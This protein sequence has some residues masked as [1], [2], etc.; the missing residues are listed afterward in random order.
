MSDGESLRGLGFF[1][2][3]FFFFTGWVWILSIP[4]PNN[5]GNIHTLPGSS[6]VEFNRVL[7]ETFESDR[8]RYPL[9]WP[10]LSESIGPK[11]HRITTKPKKALFARSESLSTPFFF[12]LK[13]PKL[14]WIWINNCLFVESKVIIIKMRGGEDNLFVSGACQIHLVKQISYYQ[15]HIC[16]T[17]FHTCQ[18][19]V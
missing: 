11:T 8:V 19:F 13:I 2:F 6:W 14:V 15:F 16:Q 5:S 7:P 3:F 1:F 9:L 10:S 17:K 12:P 4:D 18:T